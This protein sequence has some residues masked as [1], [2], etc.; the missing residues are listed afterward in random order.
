M[1]LALWRAGRDGLACWGVENR[2]GVGI[3]SLGYAMRRLAVQPMPP[4]Q[5]TATSLAACVGRTGLVLTDLD[6]TGFVDLEGK[7]LQARSESSEIHIPVGARIEVI[8]LDSA[9]LVVRPQPEPA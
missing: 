8:G 6:P 4:I 5:P 1:L 7:R 3:G 9:F 2:A